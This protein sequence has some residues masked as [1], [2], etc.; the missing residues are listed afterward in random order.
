M[1]SID[2]VTKNIHVELKCLCLGLC[3]FRDENNKPKNKIVL[4]KI[5]LKT[6]NMDKLC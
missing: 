5:D 6:L 3:C 1:L 4:M 2:H